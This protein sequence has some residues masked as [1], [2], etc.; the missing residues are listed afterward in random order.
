M[1]PDD[2]PTDQRALRPDAGTVRAG[3]GERPPGGRL[4]AVLPE[5]LH[6]GGRARRLSRG[7]LRAAQTNGAPAWVAGCC[8]NSPASPSAMAM[9]GSNGPCWTGTRRRSRSTNRWA[10]SP[11]A[12]WTVYRLTGPAL[13]GRQPE[14]RHPDSDSVPGKRQWKPVDPGIGRLA[15]QQVSGHPANRDQRDPPTELARWGRSTRP[16]SPPARPARSDRA[17]DPSAGRAGPRSHRPPAPG[18][19]RRSSRSAPMSAPPRCP[20]STRRRACCRPVPADR[21]PRAGPV[22]RRPAPAAAAE[23]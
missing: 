15:D 12:G 10:R 14:H 18:P 21:P 20:R 13:Q 22:L 23:W 19:A 7:P 5:L 11:M 9:P 16:R 4:R 8:S 6:L 17:S 2:G 3:R 1:P